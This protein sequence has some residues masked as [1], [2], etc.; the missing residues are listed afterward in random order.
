MLRQRAR[1]VSTTLFA[2]DLVAVAAAFFF[3]YG[4][5]ARFPSAFL[6]AAAP[7]S[8]YLPLV[9]VALVAWSVGGG[10]AQFYRS[11]R[12]RP[13][14]LDLLRVASVACTVGAATFAGAFALRLLDVSRVFVGLFTLLVFL[15][16][17]GVRVAAWLVVRS[18]RRRGQGLRT[19]AIVGSGEAAEE[20]GQTIARHS[21][22]GLVVAGYVDAGS[23]PD[24]AP[25]RPLLGALTD[26]ASILETQVI[27]EV[28]FAVGRGRL[29]DLEPAFLTCE[30]LGVGARLVLN[31]FPHKLSRLSFEEMDG[32]PVLGFDTVPT[33][34]WALAIKRAFDVVLSGVALVLL[35][36]LFALV[37]AA[38]KMSSPGP[39]LFR[40]RRVGLNGR[41]FWF[42][43]FRSMVLNAE[44]QRS[45]LAVHNEA[46]GPVF[47]IRH[48]PRL[49]A[50]GAA[51][52]KTSLDELPQLWH[53]FAGEMSIV[54]PRPPIPSEVAQYKRW[55][56]RRLSMK[57][58]L[59]CFWQVSGRSEIGFEE[60]MQLD[61]RYIDSWSLWLDLK[62]VLRT[63]PA[64]L[65]GRGAH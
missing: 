1:V 39:V 43:K 36:P 15:G 37:A 41:E 2:A 9:A 34:A 4:L 53:V 59:T 16:T 63:I 35:A 32:I 3:A 65:L 13:V 38:V 27:D 58:G 20:V 25:L 26:L 11:R 60:W 6:R 55:Q 8:A 21:E 24:G 42:L 12:V 61:L 5:R 29:D 28:I 33:H 62:L 44:A 40:Q 51:L 45:S 56:R 19:V 52:R 57:P 14:S 7:L 30:E 50:V 48:D 31:F 46:D 17:T 10:L 47:K 54:G 49:T 22:W 64:V 23:E 18:A